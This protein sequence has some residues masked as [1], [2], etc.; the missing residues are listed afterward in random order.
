MLSVSNEKVTLKEGDVQMYNSNCLISYLS[1]EK[2][3]SN[4]SYS[5][6]G[7]SVVFLW[8]RCQIM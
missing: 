2:V 7:V 5:T 3:G 8:R 1:I 6:G 4:D